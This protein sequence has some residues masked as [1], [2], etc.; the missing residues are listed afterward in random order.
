[1]EL[2]MTEPVYDY[3]FDPDANAVSNLIPN[4]LQTITAVNADEYHTVV[5]RYAPFYAADFEVRMNS[6]PTPLVEGV[7]YLLVY[8]Y[9]QATVNLTQPVYGGIVLLNKSLAGTIRFH[10]RTVGGQWTLGLSPYNVLL[11]NI[12][13][14]P[15][16]TTWEQVT[17]TPQIF[18]VIEHIHVDDEDMTGLADIVESIDALTSAIV[19]NMANTL[20]NNKQS[21]GIVCSD[22]ETPIVVADGVMYCVWQTNFLIERISASLKVAQ[23][24]GP[25]FTVDVTR[26]GV[27]LFSTKITFDNNQK[28][29]L[30]ATIQS[31]LANNLLAPGD[32]LLFN[33]TQVGSGEACG[34]IVY[35]NGVPT[36]PAPV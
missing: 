13:V 3:P 27:S 19:D 10:Y 1:M 14:N 23:A 6:N 22:L 18:P 30:A 9:V 4:E 12:L 20:S 33:V 17:G 21:P 11:S 5:P 8:Q 16:Q 24:S 32:E 29:S 31:E 15:R 25:L 36:S 2:K 35:I 28:N 26:N 34:L 7:D